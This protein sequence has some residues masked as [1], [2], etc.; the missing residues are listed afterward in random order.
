MSYVIL[1]YVSMLSCCV[2]AFPA[3]FFFCAGKPWIHDGP[4]ES[5]NVH[6]DVQRRSV[7]EPKVIVALWEI[8]ESCFNSSAPRWVSL[9]QFVLLS[10]FAGST[11]ASL[12]TGEVLQHQSGKIRSIKIIEVP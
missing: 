6:R 7:S 4:P 8:M 12:G 11:V 5:T 9:S 2:L 1:M 3:P 10:P